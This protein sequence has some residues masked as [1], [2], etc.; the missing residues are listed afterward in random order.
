MISQE[1]IAGRPFAHG[2]GPTCNGVVLLH[3][4]GITVNLNFVAAALPQGRHLEPGSLLLFT[5][6]RGKTGFNSFCED[7]S[8]FF[9]RYK[10]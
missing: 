3:D 4:L 2:H 10:N 5:V 6:A 1:V 7:G 8:V 9:L